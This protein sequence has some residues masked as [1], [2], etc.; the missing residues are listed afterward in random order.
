MHT[1]VNIFF[2]AGTLIVEGTSEQLSPVLNMLK[3]DER[4]KKYRTQAYLYSDII[5]TL[6]KK[7][8]H[9]NDYAKEFNPI[10]ISF[11]TNLT[12]RKHQQEAL[13]HWKRNLYKGVVVMPTGSG[14]SFF[15]YMAIN[16][17]KR[18][19][20]IVVP[21]IDLMQ[22]WAS[23]IERYFDCKCGMLGG[24]IKEIRDITV[25]TYDSAL[26]HMEFIGNKFAFIV[27]DECHHLPGPTVKTA[28]SMSLAP[29]RLGLTATPEREDR[30]EEVL[31]K[32]VGPLVYEVHI[33]EL[34]GKILAPYIT[35]KIFI[36]LDKEEEKEYQKSRTFY[37]NFIRKTGIDF[38]KKNA[39]QDFIIKTATH[40]EGKKALEAYITQ[41]N[42]ARTAKNKFKKIWDL[43][44]LHNRE[45]IIIFTADNPT[46]YKIGNTFF[47]PV[48]TH[49]TKLTERKT[50]LDKFRNGE[51][52]VLVT[53]KV[54]NEGVDVPEAN[55]G[56]IVSGSAGIREHVQR[57]GRILRAKEN[58]QAILYELISDNTSE[59]NISE[60]RRQHRAYY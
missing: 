50:F 31:Y 56:I 6:R 58:K 51:Y 14:K 23:Q 60:R 54:L 30:G 27:F 47:L 44:S 55:V 43:I 13:S 4:I 8:I 9:H 32:L 42:I 1:P 38:R 39:W 21:T 36:H 7:N 5:L 57:L 26:I 15:A 48:I 45:R 11:K 19:T 53:S 35:K 17:L 33:D 49:K 40:P 28:A 59:I 41:K 46:A 12:A 29:Y 24:G 10:N 18:P 52:P 2:S 22:Q 3:F 20:L 16:Y 25:T 37:T 34:K